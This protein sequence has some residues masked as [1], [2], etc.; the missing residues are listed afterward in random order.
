MLRIL[1][2]SIIPLLLVAGSPSA[3]AQALELQDNV[4][5][6]YTVVKG[7]TLWDISGRF[8]KKPWRWPEIW[9]MNR[10]Q[11]RN[12]H[13]IYPGDVVMLSFAGG[14]PH[15]I[16]SG[17]EAGRTVKLAPQIRATPID[18]AIPS[19]PAAVIEPFL[20]RPLVV[21]ADRLRGAPVILATENERMIVAAGNTA[22]V[23]SLTADQANLWQ[24]YRPGRALKDP[25][26]GELL[27][28]EAIYLG[29]ARVTRLGDPTTVA[30]TRS[31]QEIN[32]GDRLVA[33]SKVSYP[34]YA[35]RAPDTSL[36]GRIILAPGGVSEIGQNSVVV[37]NR[38]TRDGL[39]VG[40]VLASYRL[41]ASVR[42]PDADGQYRNS[43]RSSELKL[44]DERNGLIFI[45]RTFDRVAYG[46]VVQSLTP[47]HI[48]DV[49]QSPK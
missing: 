15:L 2:G 9:Q 23:T 42:A 39:E 37:V 41:G 49:V 8:L 20:T 21:D 38:G 30:I 45:F 17:R 34:T 27:G 12:P 31:T 3:S 24:I 16:L 10:D 29:D 13:L 1:V 25:D 14:Q 43:W 22:Y 44:P 19:I 33:A 28:Y 47:I 4:P 18:Q 35:P 32:R 11:I 6:R 46:L 26:S 48:G 5:S 36:K 40:H 7:D